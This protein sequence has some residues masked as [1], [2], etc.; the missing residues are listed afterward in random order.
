MAVLPA[1]EFTP[2]IIEDLREN[3]F[4]IARRRFLDLL[5]LLYSESRHGVVVPMDES[6]S[7]TR[8]LLRSWAAL[9][10]LAPSPS[11]THR[12]YDVHAQNFAVLL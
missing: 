11:S 6:S 8:L 9:L 10:P 5:A 12:A 3:A 1:V 2:H 7:F 4:R